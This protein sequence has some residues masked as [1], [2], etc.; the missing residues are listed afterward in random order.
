MSP[1]L[2]TVWVVLAVV[3]HLAVP[4][5]AYATASLAALPG[6]ICSDS[7]G[8]GAAPAGQDTPRP[9]GEHHC[10][11]AACCAGGAANSAAAPPPV[12]VVHRM[13]QAGVS[14]PE[15]TS[16]AAPFAVIIAA[17]PRGP[18]LIA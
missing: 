10:A 8:A 5:A 3:A 9:S 12:L 11:H 18:P 14:A 6:D 15:A 13:A 17:Q 16:A 4:V 7:R 1:N 2:R